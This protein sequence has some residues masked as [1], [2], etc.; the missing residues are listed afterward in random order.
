MSQLNTKD[1]QHVLEAVTG[2]TPSA[3]APQCLPL[4]DGSIRPGAAA[5]G[6]VKTYCSVVARISSCSEIDLIGSDSLV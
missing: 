2:Y 3:L 1:V 4:Q 5:T 6:D